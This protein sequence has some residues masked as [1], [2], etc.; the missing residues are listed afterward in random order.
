MVEVTE[1]VESDQLAR[2]M[3]S[4]GEKDTHVSGKVESFGVMTRR[5]RTE[6]GDN[7]RGKEKLR[8]QSGEL[9]GEAEETFVP[10]EMACE[11]ASSCF[12]ERSFE[13]EKSMFGVK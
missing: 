8:S 3:E 11:A 10:A 1:A 13:S 6:M 2:D 12:E 5:Q 9:N 4:K 7:L